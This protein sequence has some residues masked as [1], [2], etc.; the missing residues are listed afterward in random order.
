MKVILAKD[1]QNLGSAN[2]IKEVADGYARNFLIP[3]GFAKIATESA[4]KQAEELKIEKEKRAEEELKNIQ[5]MA[6]KLEG[7]SVVIKAKADQ[8]KKLYAAV[9]PKEISEALSLK[10]FN[11]DES[12]IV[13]KE[14]IKEIGEYEVTANLK[15]GLEVRIGVVVESE[16]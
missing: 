14:P 11:V 1:V 3:G 15:H 16:K 2:D 7:V 5:E 8:T 10:G 4:V 12:K 6:E 9:K 13:I